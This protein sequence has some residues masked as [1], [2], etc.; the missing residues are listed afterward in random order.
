MCLALGWGLPDPFDSRPSLRP[1]W[2][3]DWDHSHLG[4]ARGVAL[5]ECSLAPALPFLAVTFG[6]LTSSPIKCG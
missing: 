4:H 2:T 3:E 1:N 5:K 6:A